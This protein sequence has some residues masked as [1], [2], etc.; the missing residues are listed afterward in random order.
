[1]AVGCGIEVGFEVTVG[2]GVAVFAGSEVN[3]GCSGVKVAVERT[4]PPQASM[5][6]DATTNQP[7]FMKKTDF[8]T[9]FV[10]IS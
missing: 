4:P 6:I 2:F 8:E 3:V 10:F 9:D 1:V 5:I 7:I